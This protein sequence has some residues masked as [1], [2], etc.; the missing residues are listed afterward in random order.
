[1]KLRKVY[2]IYLAYRALSLVFIVLGVQFILFNLDYVKAAVFLLL[3]IFLTLKYSSIKPIP[4]EAKCLDK[5]GTYVQ[6]FVSLGIIISF[7]MVVL[8]MF[9]YFNEQSFSLPLLVNALLL[10]SFM[11]MLYGYFCK[12]DV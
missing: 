1:M 3:G 6:M 2:V 10:L 7:G 9:S 8:S 4:Q 11:L 12:K 5:R